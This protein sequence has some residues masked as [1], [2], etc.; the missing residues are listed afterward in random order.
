VKLGLSLDLIMTINFR[1]DQFILLLLGIVIL[2][3][4]QNQYEVLQSSLNQIILSWS[5]RKQPTT[6]RS[7]TEVG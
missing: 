3:H 2:S 6:T 1:E 4:D 5:T 7:S